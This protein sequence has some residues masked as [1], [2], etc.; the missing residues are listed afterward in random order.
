MTKRRRID[1]ARPRAA[2]GPPAAPRPARARAPRNA[3]LL[4]G[5]LALLVA[6]LM[7]W[8]GAGGPETPPAA[9]DST[10]ALDGAGALREAVA[11]V[12]RGERLKSIP[13]FERA[14]EQGTGREDQV[15]GLYAAV[16]Q[17]VALDS[18]VR[19]SVERTRIMQRALQEIERVA[20]RTSAPEQRAAFLFQH[21]YILR[22][23]GF[24]VDAMV[25]LNLAG[26]VYPGEPVIDGAR[27][28]LARRLEHPEDPER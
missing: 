13:Y 21:A 28:G 23:F 2:P 16:L 9:F 7:W 10:A 11:R 8:R 17:D 19:S 12:D 15:V 18:T 14:L 4:A 26:T 5:T 3:L 25:E 22:V 27:L 20:G 6:A 24:P 1:R